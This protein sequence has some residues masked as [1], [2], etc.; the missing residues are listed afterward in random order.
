MKSEKVCPQL[1]FTYKLYLL[2]AVE[3]EGPGREVGD[4]ASNCSGQEER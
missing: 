3:L 2:N 4:S 1:Q